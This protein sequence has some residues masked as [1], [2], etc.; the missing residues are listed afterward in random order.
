M[1]PI[2]RVL[3]S[4]AL[5][6]P[7]TALNGCIAVAA[8]AAGAAYFLGDLEEEF[9]N[10][11]PEVAKAVTSALEDLG[12]PIESVRVTELDGKV[13]AKTATD[14]SISVLIERRPNDRTWISLRVGSFGDEDSSRW[15]M[16]RIRHHLGIE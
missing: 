5:V 13:L 1:R 3:S 12:I 2:T 15:I 6:L 7:L 16:E 9:D 11:P 14:K 4:V 8:A 10:S